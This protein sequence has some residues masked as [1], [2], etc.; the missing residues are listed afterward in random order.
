MIPLNKPLTKNSALYPQISSND[1]ISGFCK[2]HFKDH[3]HTILYSSRVGLQLVYKHLYN[4]KGSLRVG[5]SP[6]TCFDALLPIVA[7]K[8]K[9]VFID[10][11]PET[12]NLDEEQLKNYNNLDVIQPIHLGGNPQR[13]EIIEN[14]AKNRGVVIVED[15]AQAIGSFYNGK[16]VGFW[17]D[18]SVFSLTKALIAPA[19]SLLLSKEN[20]EIRFHKFLPKNIITYKKLKRF[21]ESKC[22]YGSLNLF[23]LMY[24]L[25]LTLR[26]GGADNHTHTAYNLPK[27]LVN[28]IDRLVNHVSIIN[29]KRLEVTNFL[30]EELKPNKFT[31]QKV[32]PNGVSNRNR[33]L[34]LSKSIEAKEI[35]RKLR[36]KGIA[37]NN[38]TQS[39]L[40]GFQKTVGESTFFE[41]YYSSATLKNYEL[42]HPFL[43][44]I[45]NS[46]AL[47]E[48]EMSHITNAINKI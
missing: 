21:L 8:H 18:Y 29:Q 9:I 20:L 6:L 33:L 1:G 44:S 37:A 15:C 12:F 26:E 38:L 7:N 2:K 16:H 10:I 27:A 31:I 11:D 19:G 47:S 13:M 4:S 41:T 14:W 3:N 43:F 24:W 34:V 42:I 40:N 25:L 36:A 22:S 48:C 28:D 46:P 39:Y 35:I 5:V 23:N 32:T 30:I 45:P 17:G